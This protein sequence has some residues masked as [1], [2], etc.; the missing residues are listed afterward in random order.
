[1]KTKW[2]C[3][4]CNSTNICEKSEHMKCFVCEYVMVTE[5]PLA[6]TKT[7]LAEEEITVP[8]K[9]SFS[10]RIKK[11]VN[12]IKL[13]FRPKTETAPTLDVV[14]WE[15][16]RSPSD[17]R[18]AY[19]EAVPVYS[20]ERIPEE[21]A[22]FSKAEESFVGDSESA[23]RE[24]IIDETE[25]TTRTDDAPESLDDIT[26][27]SEHLMKFDLDRL[28]DTGC[29]AVEKKDV[30]GNKCYR[31]LY[32]NGA[33]K[34]LTLANMKIMG[35]LVGIDATSR[36]DADTTSRVETDIT[37]KKDVASD[38]TPWPEH[39]IRFNMDKLNSTGCIK[40]ER[41]EISGT[42]CYRLTYRNGNDRIMN[43]QNMKLLGF[44]IDA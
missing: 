8:E 28:R 36:V 39:R 29:I 17:S 12:S 38:T 7:I 30:G 40:I 44:A 15:F 6:D 42:K 19:I 1:M 33:E 41:T 35:Y 5:L 4:V 34:I 20:D 10:D 3:P 13:A 27:W 16:R 23:E 26:P 9:P 43:A 31:V 32:K 11:I 18:E 22:D 37:P 24:W 25:S 2:V 21:K 14:D